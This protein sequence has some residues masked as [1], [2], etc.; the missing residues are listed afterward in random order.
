M[1][2]EHP[3][4]TS[5]LGEGLKPAWR[6]ACVAYRR[7][8]QSGQLDHPAWLAARAAIQELRADLDE[9]VAG[10]QAS[11]AIHYASV[12]HAKWLWHRVGDPRHRK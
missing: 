3:T 11:A 9:H 10:Q 12:N 7:A 6:V 1:V 2:G 4:Q 8:R 5:L